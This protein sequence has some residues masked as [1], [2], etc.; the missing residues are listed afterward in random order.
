MKLKNRQTLY[1]VVR[2]EADWVLEFGNQVFYVN[3]LCE[4]SFRTYD[5]AD[6]Y[7]DS[8]TQANLD[9]NIPAEKYKYTVEVSIYYDE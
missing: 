5:A 8:L 6:N 2:T 7:K 4:G 9:K 1:T 3:P